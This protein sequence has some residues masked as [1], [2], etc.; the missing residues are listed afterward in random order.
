MKSFLKT[1]ALII[2]NIIL[3]CA[4]VVTTVTFNIGDS[5]NSAVSSGVKKSIATSYSDDNIEELLSDDELSDLIDK[6]SSIY[7]EAILTG[8]INDD[9]LKEDVINYIKKHKDEL[10][11]K[12]DVNIQDSDIED[13]DEE[14]DSLKDEIK[15]TINEVRTGSDNGMEKDM[16]SFISYICSDNYKI[17]CISVIVVCI[18]LNVL[19]LWSPYKWMLPV[20]ISGVVSGIIGIINS[21]IVGLISTVITADSGMNINMNSSFILITNLIILVLGIVFLIINGNLSKKSIK[22]DKEE[23]ETK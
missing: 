9:D 16:L 15:T 21:L 22:K 8:D 7:T 4:I 2:V 6:Y 23:K 19:I 5:I 14:I 20:G 18:L 17:T 1:F 11:E 10:N 12:Y 3:V 13:L